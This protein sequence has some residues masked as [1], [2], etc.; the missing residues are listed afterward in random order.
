[1]RTFPPTQC[2]SEASGN[3]ST[4]HLDRAVRQRHG[5]RA[6][7]SCAA[8]H[9]PKSAK[10]SF[11]GSPDN[12]S[13]CLLS[14][15]LSSGTWCLS[16]RVSCVLAYDSP[17]SSHPCKL[18]LPTTAVP[19]CQV[20]ISVSFPCVDGI[21]C[22]IHMYKYQCGQYSKQQGTDCRFRQT[23]EG[24]IASFIGGATG[25]EALEMGADGGESSMWVTFFCRAR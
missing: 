16:P 5:I 22:N 10:I 15:C 9:A 7:R 24:P 25:L 19:P 17:S 1:M 18:D 8:S 3:T 20:S 2:S 21:A 11:D 12:S 4:D 6:T 14:Q 13:C 23:C